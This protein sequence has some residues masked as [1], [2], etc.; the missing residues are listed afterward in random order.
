MQGQEGCRR[1]RGRDLPQSRQGTGDD[2]GWDWGAGARQGKV[3]EQRGQGCL[4]GLQKGTVNSNRVST[5]K[6][7]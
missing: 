4:Q 7:E 6:Q 2:L 1:W 3:E 5:G